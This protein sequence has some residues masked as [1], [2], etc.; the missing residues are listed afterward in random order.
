MGN[1]GEVEFIKVACPQ[2]KMKKVYKSM[3][4]LTIPKT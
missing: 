1:L 4:F 2:K 3:T